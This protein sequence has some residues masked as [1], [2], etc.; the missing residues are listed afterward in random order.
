MT[1]NDR[2]EKKLRKLER[3]F[4]E[5][6]VASDPIAAVNLGYYKHD[7]AVPN[8]TRDR[9]ILYGRTL[10]KFSKLFSEINSSRLTEA[11]A[12]DLQAAGHHIALRLFEHEELRYW[13]S[14]PDAATVVGASISQL[15]LRNYAPLTDRL[16]S[17]IERI[18]KLPRYIDHSMT[19]LTAPMKPLIELE[20]ENLTL[21][22]GFFHSLTN[23][24]RENLLKTPFIT[25]CRGLDKLQNSLEVYTNWLIIDIIPKCREDCAPIM[26]KYPLILKRMGITASP[27][28]ILASAEAHVVR[29]KVKLRA[30]AKSVK[31]NSSVEEVRETIRSRHPSNTDE[32]IKS[33]TEY[34]RKARNFVVRSNFATLPSDDNLYIIET[35][36]HH[37]YITPFTDVFPA[38]PFDKKQYGFLCF[39]PGNSENDKLKEHNF[40]A[41]SLATIYNGYPGRHLLA[42]C[43]NTHQSFFRSGVMAPD[44]FDGWG[45]YC[46]ERVKEY[47][48]EETKEHHYIHTLQMMWRTIMAIIDIKLATG[49]MDRKEAA[50]FL[51]RETGMDM[52]SAESEAHRC[53][54]KPGTA[55]CAFH[56]K[57]TIK[58]LK[59]YARRQMKGKFNERFFHD[60][61]L[62]AGALPLSL[63]K[64]ELDLK[65]RAAL[66][67]SVAEKK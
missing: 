62:Y 43:S 31:R 4:L 1:R 44:T 54:L 63:A 14:Y 57:E 40:A 5:F 65:I 60:V 2:E 59:R 22:P 41:I 56:G 8:G 16:K 48:Y 39:T 28:K 38:A 33:A 32:V 34:V 30:I 18:H 3:Q 52:L 26:D 64:K 58:E 7:T 51:S 25:L 36:H 6:V 20:L 29:L 67:H 53:L 35:P 12:I 45:H 21:L 27:S 23:I 37:R 9:E 15:L 66:R 10:A 19:K 50:D 13:E 46:E 24:A 49:A 42:L 61:L 47:G 17:I 55:L 11:R